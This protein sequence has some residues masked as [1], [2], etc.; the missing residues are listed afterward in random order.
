MDKGQ[1]QGS[2]HHFWDPLFILTFINM[3]RSGAARNIALASQ[4]LEKFDDMK[5][6]CDEVLGKVNPSSA[7]WQEA[8]STL[9]PNPAQ[10][11]H[12]SSYHIRDHMG[13]SVNKEPPPHLHD[14]HQRVY[15]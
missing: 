12:S 11:S 14:A 9:G 1:P 8:F 13:M 5:K 6:A 7:P 15:N 3:W 4:K 10:V 2:R